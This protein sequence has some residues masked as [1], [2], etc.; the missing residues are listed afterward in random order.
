VK[1]LTT[2]SFRARYAQAPESVQ[3][4]IRAA[5]QLW[6]QNPGHPSLRFKKVHDRLPIYSA[7][8]GLDWRVV[9]VLKEDAMIWFFVGPHSEYER[10]LKQL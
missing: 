1:S 9:G 6:A 5:H 7:R 10:L 3:G 8:V 2:E 4:R